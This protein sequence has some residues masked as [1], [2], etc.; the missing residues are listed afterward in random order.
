[1]SMS[2]TRE[3]ISEALQT[4]GLPGGAIVFVHSSMS[5]IG[6]VEGGATT[7]VDA[8]LQVLTPSGTL[9]APAFTFSHSGS[10]HPVFN[11]ALDP[12]EMGRFTEETRTRPGAR[13]S[14]HLL[15]SVAA[16]GRQA[17]EVAAIHGPS[18]WAADGP[19][20]KLNELDAYILLLGVPYLR[21][22]FIHLLEQLVQVP[23][24][25]WREIEAHVRGPDGS[26]G[27]LP[28]LVYG[29]KP[30]F[31][32]NDFNKL[33]VLLEEKGLVQV[34]RVGNAVARLFRARDAF[35]VGLAQYRV[36]PS[37]FLRDGERCTPLPDGVLTDDLNNEKSVIDPAFIY[38][39]R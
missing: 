35:E 3:Q 20:W 30:G 21:C 27:E 17:A 10:A 15:H 33:G 14:N 2:Q 32:G 5:S 9:A 11:P 8:F 7:L 6:H 28:T 25:H 19:F 38:R 36:D 29:P 4:L 34:G 37:I 22:T 16:L 13:R 24:R 12:S 1:M 23:Y 39:G 31:A 26:L 18:A